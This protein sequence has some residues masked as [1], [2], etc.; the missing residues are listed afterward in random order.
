VSET[1]GQI[2]EI[3]LAAIAIDGA[4]LCPHGGLHV[5]SLAA[6]AIERALSRIKIDKLRYGHAMRQ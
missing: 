5:A 2:A 6:T 1:N 3:M 4:A